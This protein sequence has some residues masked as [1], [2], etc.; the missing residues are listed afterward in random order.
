MG[1]TWMSYFEGSTT[2]VPAEAYTLPFGEAAVV[3]EEKFRR[4]YQWRR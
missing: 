2:H 4:I 3:R 1:L